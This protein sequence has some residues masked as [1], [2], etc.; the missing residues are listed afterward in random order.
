V[1]F[2]DWD[3]SNASFGQFVSAFN[4]QVNQHATTA[5]FSATGNVNGGI[6]Q[7]FSL[8]GTYFSFS[9]PFTLTY[10]LSN[11]T[12]PA[13]FTFDAQVLDTTTNTSLG[14][15]GSTGSANGNYSL[16]FNAPSGAADLLKLQFTDTPTV[17][18][19]QSTTLGAVNLTTADPAPGPIP[20][21]GF[22]SYIALGL[23]GLGSFGWKRLG[24]A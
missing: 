10:T 20:G 15:S 6:I 12:F 5:D 2:A 7:I 16:T 23:L 21:A 17:N 9:S 22:L 13:R 1:A 4:G 11:G 18:G 8:P 3:L 19:T 24:K 14:F